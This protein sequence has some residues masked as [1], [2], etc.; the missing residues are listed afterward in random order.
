MELYHHLSSL[1]VFAI[2]LAFTPGPN[3]VLLMASGA[4]F[5]FRRTIPH[6][7]GT[8][9]GFLVVL[10]GVAFGLGV[11][12]ARY[13]LAQD[14][15]K[16]IGCV[17][18]LYLAWRIATTRRFDRKGESRP[19]SFYEAAGF[20]LVNPKGWMAIVSGMTAFTL[21]GEAYDRSAL[22]VVVVFMIVT[23]GAASTWAGFG[24]AIGSL[25]QTEKAYRIFNLTMGA[26]TASAVVLLFL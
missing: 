26:L 12:F 1:A 18:L 24:T 8:M 15:L 5:G 7:V 22:M 2:A 17:Y 20:Q 21:S 3:N 23:A 11:V 6:L 10:V 13:P 4:N 14:V 9:F 25:L 16:F 19:F